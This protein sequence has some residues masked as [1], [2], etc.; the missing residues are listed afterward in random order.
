MSNLGFQTLYRLFNDLEV[1]A[2]E[3]AFLPDKDELREFEKSGEKLFSLES[4]TPLERFDII[5]FSVSFEE[6]FINI[7][8]ILALAGVPLFSIERGRAHPLVMAGGCAVSLNPEPV[9]EFM[10]LCF[11]GEAEGMVG[12]F[13]EA[14]GE[15]GQGGEEGGLES[16][17]GIEGVYVPALYEFTY[18]GP[19]VASIKAAPGAPER[20][21]RARADTDLSPVPESVVLTPATEFGSATLLEVERGCGRG[22]RFC[23]AGFIYLP[24]RMRE[25]GPVKEI[26][27]RGF[28]E[29]GKV[30]LVGAAVSEYPHLKELLRLGIEGGREMTLSSLRLDMLDAELLDLLKKAGYRTVTLA[31][32]AGTERLRRVVNKD[33][34]D[35]EIDEAIRL[36]KEAGFRKLKLYFMVGLPTETDADARA[37]GELSLRLKKLMGKGKLTLSINPFMPKPFTPFQWHPFE[38]V[39]TIEKRYSIIKE[40]LKREGGIDVKTLSV[41]KAFA[42]AYLSRADRRAGRVI[43]EASK[44]GLRRALRS[45]DH[46]APLAEE[47]VHRER[48][49][50]EP[51]PWEVVDHGLERGYLWDEYQRGLEGKTTPPCEVGS[52]FR[53]GV[54]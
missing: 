15:G 41:R 30:G 13:I 36:V 22:C 39:E 24:P 21:T 20:V 6:D 27:E 51:F 1:C 48:G 54:C 46:P 12:P 3:R 7:P 26:V 45:A 49:V 4:Q 18:D 23:A 42:Q 16:L 43:A 17:A 37:I 9:A 40:M 44:V 29:S 53:C 52:C 11:I 47:C 19:R 8:R 32:E 25:L 33:I 28:R 14:V 38:R 35:S 10:D 50:D 2:C 34:S 31:P 5:A